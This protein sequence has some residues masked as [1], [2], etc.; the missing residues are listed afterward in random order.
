[1]KNFIVMLAAAIIAL[2]LGFGN[3]QDDMISSG[4]NNILSDEAEPELTIGI[5]E[6]LDLPPEADSKELEIFKEKMS[7]YKPVKA[8]LER[9]KAITEA[10]FKKVWE[11]TAD[12][13]KQEIGPFETFKEFPEKMAIYPEAG[14]IKSIKFY[15]TDKVKLTIRIEKTMIKED[16]EWKYNGSWQDIENAK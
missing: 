4:S 11:L 10:D 8:F 12:Q 6:D 14:E 13:L 5:D 7:K 16:G 2:F 1:M 15:G 3:A 9:E